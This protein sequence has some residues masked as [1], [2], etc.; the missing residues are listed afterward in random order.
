MAHWWRIKILP[1][2]EV[3]GASRAVDPLSEKLLD[4]D[5]AVFL[6]A[7]PVPNSAALKMLIRIQLEQ[8]CKT[9]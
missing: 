8:I 2:A 9:L 4:P 5:P 3:P 1:E 7:D 6:K